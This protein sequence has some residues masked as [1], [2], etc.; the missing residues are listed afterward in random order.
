MGSKK[1][2]ASFGTRMTRGSEAGA[3]KWDWKDSG[4]EGVVG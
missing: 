4:I 2:D 1:W 3:E